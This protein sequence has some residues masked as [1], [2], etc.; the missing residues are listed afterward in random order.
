MRNVMPPPPILIKAWV[1]LATSSES[2]EVRTRANEMIS[3]SFTGIDEAREYLKQCNINI[4]SDAERGGDK[5]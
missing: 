2:D 1:E 5:S 4:V 3:N